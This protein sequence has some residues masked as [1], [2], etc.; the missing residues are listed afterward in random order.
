MFNPHLRAAKRVFV[1][2]I[3]F[4]EPICEIC[5]TKNLDRI[6]LRCMQ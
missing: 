3:V 6:P 5:A 1:F 2:V 4:V